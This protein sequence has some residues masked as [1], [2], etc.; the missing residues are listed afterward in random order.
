MI[1]RAWS[2]CRWSEWL[3]LKW[4]AVCCKGTSRS[5]L[6]PRAISTFSALKEDHPRHKKQTVRGPF[7]PMGLFSATGD[8]MRQPDCLLWPFPMEAFCRFHNTLVLEAAQE[9]LLGMCQPSTNEN[10]L[11]STP[12]TAGAASSL[13][14]R[15]MRWLIRVR[16]GSWPHCPTFKEGFPNTATL[17]DSHPNSSESHTQRRCPVLEWS[18]RG[19]QIILS[20]CVAFTPE[21]WAS[22]I[23]SKGYLIIICFLPRTFFTRLI[24]RI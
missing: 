10:F 13:A 17:R 5:S 16:S 23:L 7:M 19:R 6:G 11:P 15:R 4:V 1:D 22:S 8:L 12:A 2:G 3:S 14:G 21:R 9:M 20:P 24:S 18:S